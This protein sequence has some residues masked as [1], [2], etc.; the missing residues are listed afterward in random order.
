MIYINFKTYPAGTGP[1]AVEMAEMIRRVSLV[2]GI[3]VTPVVQAFSAYQVSQVNQDWAWGQH[4]DAIKYGSHTGWI[5]PEGWKQA[6]ING[7]VLNHAEHKLQFDTL[8]MTVDRCRAVGLSIGICADSLQ[9]VEK[10][11]PLTPDWIAYEPPEL[12]GRS[13]ISVATAEPD[14][15]KSAVALT[16]DSDTK[17]LIGAGIHDAN[18]ISIGLQLGAAGFFIAS[19]IMKADNPEAALRQLLSGYS[20]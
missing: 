14:V 5:L 16:T 12:I 7:V 3:P 19:A 1:Q 2:V 8:K 9:E 13:D 15:V 10:I 20:D 11:L 6:G 4:A 18:D 17:L